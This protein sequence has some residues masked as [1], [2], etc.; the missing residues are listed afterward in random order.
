MMNVESN[1]G[2]GLNKNEQLNKKEAA[3]KMCWADINLWEVIFEGR[4]SVQS[5]TNQEN[6]SDEIGQTEFFR[7]SLQ[8]FALDDQW[9]S[10]VELEFLY[11]EDYVNMKSLFMDI[12]LV[13]KPGIDKEFRYIERIG[14]GSQATVDLYK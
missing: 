2:S 13:K 5:H 7:I 9:N 1:D 10:Q 14:R 4:K 6:A 11:E 8:A 3:K 12:C